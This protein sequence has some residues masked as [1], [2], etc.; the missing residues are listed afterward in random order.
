MS[1][2]FATFALQCSMAAV[3]WS[4]SACGNGGGEVCTMDSQCASHFCR[5]D[6]TCGPAESDGGG[7][8]G[9]GSGS[10][11]A[12]SMGLCAPNHDGMISANEVPL[13]AGKM[14]NYR[15][16]TSATWNTAGTAGSGGM[17]T[18]TLAGALANDADAPVTL[19]A[20]TGTWWAGD[21]GFA[22][23]T[24]WTTLQAGSDLIGV[25]HVDSTGVT[26]LGVVSPTGSYPY[27]EITYDPPARILAV[28]FGAAATWTSSST[29]SG[30]VSGSVVNYTEK[31]VSNVDLTGTMA[32]PYGDFPVLRVGTVLTQAV[33][34]TSN[35]YRTVRSYAWIAECF[36]SVA[37]AT[38]SDNET[39]AEFSNDAEV[40][41]II[42]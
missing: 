21:S 6:G 38:S 3:I 20:P 10:G 39:N 7:S 15:V 8:D 24:Y 9:S 17:R 31:Y 32:T 29:V 35:V 2:R 36:G 19:S 41:R 22:T 11:D 33:L 26:L 5:A 30:Y 18:W 14:A 4:G 12:G 40:R 25:F 34:G 13:A 37:T 23:A 16:A 28:P 27:T 1:S 42:P